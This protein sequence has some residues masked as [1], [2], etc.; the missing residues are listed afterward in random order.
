MQRWNL[1]SRIS[2]RSFSWAVLAAALVLV[3]A[4]VEIAR[5]TEVS[6]G[7]NDH[8]AKFPG[9]RGE[10][11]TIR[12]KVIRPQ[13]PPPVA[14]KQVT[15]FLTS[16]D[17]AK[18]VFLAP[19]SADKQTVR[20]RMFETNGMDQD[21]F[22]SVRQI[23]LLS[24]S[25][26]PEKLVTGF[27]PAEST[28]VRFELQESNGRLWA[29]RSFTV[30]RYVDGKIK[31][32]G[33]LRVRATNLSAIIAVCVVVLFLAYLTAMLAIRR[34]RNEPHPLADKYPAYRPGRRLDAKQL[35]NPIH[36]TAD[37]F[38]R[39]SVQKLQILM[40]SFL[41]AG[42][43]LSFVLMNGT[44]VNLSATIV[45][46]LGLS[47]IGAAVA[48]TSAATKDRMSFENWSWLVKKRVLP[49]NEA[50]GTGPRWR[51]LV[52]TNR[53]F[54]VYKLQTLIFSLTVAAALVV[55][56]TSN[57]SSFEV[58]AALLGILG[59]TQ[60]VYI[61]GILVRPP[62]VADLDKAITDLRKAEETAKLAVTHSVDVDANGNLPPLNAPPPNLP[63]PLRKEAAQ[64]ALRQYK[65]LADQ[66]ELMIE[67]T[68]ETEVERHRLD[69]DIRDNRRTLGP[70]GGPGGTVFSVDPIDDESEIH[71]LTVWSGAVIDAIQVTYRHR[72]TG[73]ITVGPKIGGG[74]GAENPL[75][76]E[77]GE[78]I[79]RVEGR[80]GVC[81]ASMSVQTN[82]RRWPAG[83][84]RW[85]GEA[86]ERGYD[87]ICEIGDEVIGF[88]GRSGDYI[89]SLGVIVRSRR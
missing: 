36:L 56:G 11:M 2:A 83:N 20:F 86:G 33:L 89:I 88:E 3:A 17:D 24:V 65:E 40:F 13:Q 70:E 59:L 1:V 28:L 57:L 73:Q 8:L 75:V 26:A 22:E 29:H 74:G 87:F 32:W 76:L 53:E 9:F 55:G 12:D 82:R 6:C 38:H 66:V 71:S 54:D 51:D 15:Q 18:L 63:F 31:D 52:T 79:T 69:P 80:M 10:F 72:A 49:I 84:A 85:G 60:V 43:L 45:G 77:P 48:Q 46:L 23:Q 78:Y 50:S 37:I 58:P 34:V 27:L 61:A 30:V 64:K 47:G 4:P 62:A 5:A 39:A 35:F 67:S 81:V 44:L 42:M 21:T 68:L 19:A 7:D 14:V 16:G 41:V 25:P